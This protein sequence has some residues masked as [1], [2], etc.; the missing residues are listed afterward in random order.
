[1]TLVLLQREVPDV[2]TTKS[3]KWNFHESRSSD[4][5][6]GVPVLTFPGHADFNNG[7]PVRYYLSLP[8]VASIPYT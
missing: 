5:C 4:W 7:V 2:I 6:I 8:Q 1:M 3:T